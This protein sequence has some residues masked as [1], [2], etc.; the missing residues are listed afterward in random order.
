MLNVTNVVTYECLMLPML[1]HECLMLPML[2]H[3]NV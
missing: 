3:M 2:Q 1:Q